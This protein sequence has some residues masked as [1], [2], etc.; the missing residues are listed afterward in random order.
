MRNALSPIFHSITQELCDLYDN[1]VGLV[2]RDFTVFLWLEMTD[3]RYLMGHFVSIL[4]T[5]TSEK[6][7][8]YLIFWIPTEGFDFLPDYAEQKATNLIHDGQVWEVDITS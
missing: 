5:S 6:Y 3:W 7:L 2:T 4:L 8:V 1:G